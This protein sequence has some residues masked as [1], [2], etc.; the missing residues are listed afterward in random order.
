MDK[1]DFASSGSLRNGHSWRQASTVINHRTRINHI[2]AFDYSQFIGSY[3]FATA[4]AMMTHR[5]AR[6]LHVR[7]AA[8]RQRTIDFHIDKTTA[9]SFAISDQQQISLKITLL[10]PPDRVMDAASENRCR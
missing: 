8:K 9:R 7:F 6:T 2:G 1:S 10:A 3:H 4:G 5:D